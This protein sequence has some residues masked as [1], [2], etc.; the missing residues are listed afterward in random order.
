V[1]LQSADDKIVF[2]RNTVKNVDVLGCSGSKSGKLK[3]TIPIGK[4]MTITNEVGSGGFIFENNASLARI[5]MP[6]IRVL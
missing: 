3:V 1:C 4:S 2:V 5:T 6:P